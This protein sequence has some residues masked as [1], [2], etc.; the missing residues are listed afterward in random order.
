MEAMTLGAG[1]L[2]T[3]ACCKVQGGTGE[4]CNVRCAL[5]RENILFFTNQKIYGG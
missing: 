5:E 2:R 4:G 1:N 3:L